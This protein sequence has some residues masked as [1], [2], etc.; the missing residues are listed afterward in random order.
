[1]SICRCSFCGQSQNDVDRLVASSTSATAICTRCT[2]RVLEVF[3]TG[4]D[5][6]D[7]VEPHFELTRLGREI[8]E[9]ISGEAR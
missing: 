1:M 8:A 5:L 7:P 2:M 9:R 4:E 3:A 6:P